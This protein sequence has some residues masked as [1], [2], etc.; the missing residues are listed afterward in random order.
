MQIMVYT[1][2]GAILWWLSNGRAEDN[3]GIS[4]RFKLQMQIK[5]LVPTYG[6]Q[7]SI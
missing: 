6:I 1:V 3:V 2:C 4:L 7:I 5:V